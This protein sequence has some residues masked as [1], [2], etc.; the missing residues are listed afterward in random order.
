M[1]VKLVLIQGK[2][3]G[4]QLLFGPGEYFFG[5]GPECQVR[6][7]S[8]WVSRQ[9]CLLKVDGTGA[10]MR[11]LGSRNGTLVNGA[12]L[13]EARVLNGG[14]KVQIGPVTFEVFLDSSAVDLAASTGPDILRD[15]S[16]REP[17]SSS[18]A[19]LPPM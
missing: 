11:D 19:L 17:G 13:Q 9:H 14:D 4:K 7:N 16:G 10:S 15:D 2:P 1:R 3:A 8:E 12:L 6:F 5:R 18:T